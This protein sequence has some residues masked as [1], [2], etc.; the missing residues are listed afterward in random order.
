MRFLLAAPA[1]LLATSVYAEPFNECPSKAFLTQ[2]SVSG[3]YGVNLVTGDYQVLA[4]NMGLTSSINGL[5]FNPEDRFIYGWSYQHSKPARVHSD[6]SVEPLDVDNISGAN[7][8][9][10]DVSITDNKYYVYRNSNSAGLYSIGLDPN[11]DDYLNM[12]KIVSGSSLKLAIADMAFHPSNGY[13]YAVDRKGYLYR[14]DVSSGTSSLISNTGVEG[15]FGAA[16]FDPDGNLYISRNQDGAVFRIA[17]DAGRFIA[18]FFAQGPSSSINDGSRCALAPVVDVSNT[19]IDYGDAPDSYGTSIANN[20]A[21]HGLKSRDTLYLGSYVDGESDASMYPLSDDGN[22]ENNDDDGVQFANN[23]VESSKAIAKVKVTGKGYLNAW[24]DINRNGFFD[25]NDHVLQDHAVSEGTQYVYMPIPLGVKAGDSW[26]RFRF[27]SVVGVQAIGGAPDGEVE[28]YKVTLVEQ[29]NVVTSYPSNNGY[30]TV[31]FEDNW[32]HEG[33]YDM[34]D[35]VV[36]LRTAVSR[37]SNYVTRVDL[38]GKLSA[39][40][41]A[42]H[43]GFAIRLPGIYRDQVDVDNIEYSINDQPVSF[44][45]LEN[46]REEAIF[47]VSNDV[48]NHVGS[49]ELCKYYRTEP[50]CGSDIQMTFSASI[51]MLDP[52]NVE[53]NG[54]LDPFLFATPGA[55]HGGHFVSAPGR[56]YEI[57]LKNVA[58]TEAFDPMLYDQQGDDASNIA[59]GLYF[60]TENGLPWALEIGTDWSHPEEYQD[61]GHAY[62]Y[63]SAWAQSN[64]ALNQAWYKPEYANAPLLFED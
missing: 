30:T 52:V 2:G 36:Q 41:A 59:K 53:L 35:M 58:P 3:T 47:I 4:Q 18:E 21:R 46:D 29:E 8:Y 40:G 13:A 51:P 37:K 31:A 45:P 7:F 62:P 61:I 6:F 26:A 55:W 44:E 42:Y 64:G 43:N 39:V 1:L 25:D 49:G 14:I 5:G 63:F 38:K 57:H 34:N 20:G 54:V 33:D 19:D 23:I 16:Y 28:D 50:G 17:I 48:W 12:V 24:I 11:A 22:S 27:S 10:G 9:V 15:S 32:P 56:S 60:Q